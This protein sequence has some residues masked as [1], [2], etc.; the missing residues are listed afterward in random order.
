MFPGRPQR[1]KLRP[2]RTGTTA[3]RDRDY[4][5]EGP[6][7]RPQGTGTTAAR[8]RDYG[9]KGPGLGPQRP[10]S[11]SRPLRATAG[12]R[13]D[14]NRHRVPPGRTWPLRRRGGQTP[15][16]S[17]HHLRGTLLDSR[18]RFP[19]I[20]VGLH[21][22]PTDQVFKPPP[23]R[24]ARRRSNTPLKKDTLH[25]PHGG[26]IRVIAQGFRKPPTAIRLVL[27][28]QR[29]MKDRVDQHEGRQP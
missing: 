16:P 20:L 5:R 22:F 23:A 2:Q 8:D 25:L 29:D 9:R 21:T 17:I 18:R 10:S 4:G 11:G 13:R 28:E 7:L 24:T 27:V 26:P 12:T 14:P 3:A 6:G 15:N 19:S 1:T